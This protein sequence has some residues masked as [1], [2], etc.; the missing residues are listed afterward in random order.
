MERIG[1]FCAASEGINHHYYQAACELGEWM[2]QHGKTLIYG[3]ANL[4]LMECIAAAA[5]RNGATIVGVVPTLLEEK[6]RVSSLP[7]QVIHTHN[8]SDRKDVLVEQSEVLVALPGGLGTLDE[9]FH[10]LAATTLGYHRKK[11]IL[12]NLNGFYDGLLNWLETLRS[13]K[14]IRQP[15]EHSLVEAQN[16]R[17]L[18][19]LIEQPN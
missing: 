8:L 14:F 12:Y 4:G 2:G 5:H 17:E 1:I 10:V 7:Q 16:L 11:V 13:Q 18:I 19:T 15:L 9:I 3:G 6:G